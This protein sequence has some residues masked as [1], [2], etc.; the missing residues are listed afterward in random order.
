MHPARDLELC[1]EKLVEIFE[2]SGRAL[3]ESEWFP[4]EPRSMRWWGGLETPLE[5]IATAVLVK[6]SRWRAALAALENMR[7]RGLL[8]LSRLSKADPGEIAEAIRGVGFAK[9]KARTIIA[10]SR[11]IESL[12][13]VE[14]LANSDSDMIRR[15]LLEIEGVGRET[16]DSILLFALNKPVFPVARLSVRVLARYCGGYVGGYEYTREV[17]E[18]ALGRDLYRLKLLHAGLTTVASRFCRNRD[19]LCGSCF[20]G[21]TCSYR[22]SLPTDQ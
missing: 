2:R 6:L 15:G 19:P 16:A 5:I 7:R 3:E 22:S 20:L 21:G 14:A 9:S 12:G 4:S 17:V 11:Y 10:I 1:V 8:E 18:R 13:G